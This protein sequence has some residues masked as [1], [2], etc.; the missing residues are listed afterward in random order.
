MLHLNL[1]CNKKNTICYNLIEVIYI[2]EI[3]GNYDI[4]Q[5][6]VYCFVVVKIMSLRYNAC[7]KSPRRYKKPEEWYT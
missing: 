2:I 1:N 7:L 6:F 5:I 3:I 4:L